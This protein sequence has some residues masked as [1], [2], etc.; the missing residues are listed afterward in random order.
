MWVFSWCMSNL[1]MITKLSSLGHDYSTK[2]GPN[3]DDDGGDGGDDGDDVIAAQR[4]VPRILGGAPLSENLI[5][6]QSVPPPQLIDLPRQRNS[7]HPIARAAKYNLRT[8]PRP[9][10]KFQ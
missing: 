1:E 3:D 4:S 9:N 10:P 2:T 6:Q 7:S 8:N 5:P